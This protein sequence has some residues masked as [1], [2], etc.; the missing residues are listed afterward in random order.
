MNKVS[1]VIKNLDSLKSMIEKLKD[2]ETAF[3]EFVSKVNDELGTIPE[4]YKEIATQLVEGNVPEDFDETFQDIS[5]TCTEL[6]KG[7]GEKAAQLSVLIFKGEQR[8]FLTFG[9][10]YNLDANHELYGK[11]SHVK[12]DELGENET[13]TRNLSEKILAYRLTES[14]DLL[15]DN[16]FVV[17][18]FSDEPVISVEL[19]EKALPDLSEFVA[20]IIG[21]T[22]LETEEVT[23]RLEKISNL[24][25]VDLNEFEVDETI[26]IFEGDV[27]S[28]LSLYKINE[29]ST[30][31]YL[32]PLV[33]VIK[34]NKVSKESF[35]ELSKKYSIFGKLSLE[36]LLEKEWEEVDDS[37]KKPEIEASQ[38]ESTQTPSAP[39]FDLKAKLRKSKKN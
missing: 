23:S 10:L 37:E 29:Q 24:F 18:A 6:F 21:Y 12:L 3:S 30:I 15:T 34:T 13:A 17:L 27:K 8:E 35:T 31:E 14:N 20:D 16:K 9:E 7:W 39:K 32:A 36:S 4:S 33:G 1:I 5:D 38:Q 11:E 19:S 25:T 26:S 2:N 28:L 22:G